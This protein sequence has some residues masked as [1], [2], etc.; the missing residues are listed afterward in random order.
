MAGRRAKKVPAE[1][2]ATLGI[3]VL[4]T[5][6]P[7]LNDAATGS[8][9]WSRPTMGSTWCFS[10]ARELSELP[11]VSPWQ[12]HAEVGRERGSTPKTSRED[13]ATADPGFAR[14]ARAR[15]ALQT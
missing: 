10:V 14:S 8:A 13:S 9:V 6:A 3:G 12:S 11:V 2:L 5:N 4:A 7:A 1:L 15:G